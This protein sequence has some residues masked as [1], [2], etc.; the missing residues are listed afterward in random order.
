MVFVLMNGILITEFI[1]FDD[2][3]LHQESWQNVLRYLDA[4]SRKPIIVDEKKTFRKPLDA[5]KLLK[6]YT[7]TFQSLLV[8]Q[9]QFSM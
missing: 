8:V 9:L 2:Q 7:T 5:L 1:G 3:V 6:G 4:V